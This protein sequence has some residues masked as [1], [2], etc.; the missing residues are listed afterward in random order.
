MAGAEYE[1]GK[2]SVI[3]R[4]ARRRQPHGET[5]PHTRVSNTTRDGL[6]RTGFKDD[7]HRG[8]LASAAGL[9]VTKEEHD[10]VAT[11]DRS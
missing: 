6:N 10:G 3:A 2:A 4:L 9:A 7:A 8:P 1:R 5:Q 11:G